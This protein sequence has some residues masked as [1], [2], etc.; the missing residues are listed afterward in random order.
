MLL[1]A[2]LVCAL[3]GPA[4]AAPYWVSYEGNDFP[5]NE[6]WTRVIEGDGPANRT[7][8]DGVL[9]IDSLRNTQIADGYRME[10]LLN[11]DVG[12]EFVMQWRLRVN[13]VVGNPLFLYDPGLGLIADD[14][15]DLA[16][17]IGVDGLRSVHENVVIPFE[18]GV[19]HVF[20][21]RSPDMR[22]YELQI[23]ST[24]VYRGEF[25]PFAV[26][27]SRITWGDFVRGA[28]S[29]ADWDYFRFGVVPEPGTCTLLVAL[30]C[31]AR[32]MNSTRRFS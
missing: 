20:E 3:G 25:S 5:E 19:F 15:W 9:T 31:V 2:L 14:G 23:D 4:R 27:R 28:A 13:E 7:L 16:F 10:R 11:P 26:R 29:N 22:T 32:I 8:K 21:L 24:V 17:N 30:L 1:G 18:E 6:G 12:E